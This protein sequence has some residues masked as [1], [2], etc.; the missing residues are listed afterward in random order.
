MGA[1]WEFL[2]KN[3]DSAGIPIILSPNRLVGYFY[4]NATLS[5]CLSSR[6]NTS[7]SRSSANYFAYIPSLTPDI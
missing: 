1:G 4:L 6:T 7:T 5:T 2:L 3:A